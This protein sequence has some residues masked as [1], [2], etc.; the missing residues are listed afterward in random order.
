MRTVKHIFTTESEENEKALGCF[1]MAAAALLIFFAYKMIHKIWEH[2]I[3][4]D[5]VDVEYSIT[6]ENSNNFS[7]DDSDNFL[8]K[9]WNIVFHVKNNS[10]QEIYK[11]EYK[12]T[13]YSCDSDD[14]PVSEC[15]FVETSENN[16]YPDLPPGNK[17]VAKEDVSFS[18]A[19]KIQ[20][21][22]KLEVEITDIIGVDPS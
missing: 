9:K 22:G 12:S 16:F 1:I 13:L 6:P 2:E 7:T 20:G 10:N 17:G 14:A 3:P 5:K 18:K 11:L 15:S 19:D 8:P 4:S 21:Y